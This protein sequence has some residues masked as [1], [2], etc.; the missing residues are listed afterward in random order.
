MQDS[1]P[2]KSEV[3]V[4]VTVLALFG[5]GQG[6]PGHNSKEAIKPDGGSTTEID[7]SSL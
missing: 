3:K 4:Q 5:I 7:C 6:R 1:S 2:S